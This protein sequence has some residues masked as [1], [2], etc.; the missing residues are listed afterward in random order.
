[1][2]LC[3]ANRLKLVP[4]AFFTTFIASLTAVLISSSSLPGY[5]D[6]SPFVL[7]Q[8]LASPLI[9]DVLRFRTTLTRDSLCSLGLWLT[10]KSISIA[11]S[12]CSLCAL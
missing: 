5:E 11:P 4:N 2:F 8:D 3:F 6:S 7:I 12:P 9:V 1:M 10:R